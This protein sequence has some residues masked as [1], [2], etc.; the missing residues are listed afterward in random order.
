MNVEILKV[1]TL[2]CNCY[3]LTKGNEA[4]VIDPGDEVEKIKSHL[5]NKNVLGILITHHHFDHIGA[6]N[7]LKQERNIQVFDNSNLEEKQYSIGPFTFEVIKTSG[8][9]NDSISFYF[10]DYNL[11]F[12]GD[13]IFKGS[14]GRCDMDTGNIK[15]MKESI[16]MI[17]KYN[18]NII[19]YSGHGDS[20]TLGQEKKY[21][22]Y[23]KEE[24]I[25]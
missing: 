17:K 7:D 3:I 6:L 2:K 22:M 4:L 13:F 1:G 15:S 25:W 11:M 19:I 24:N 23:F 12:V 21:N 18:D 14:I 10:K 5:N 16:E 9:S 8:H 20:T